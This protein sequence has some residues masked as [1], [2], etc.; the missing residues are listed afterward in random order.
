MAGSA[1]ARRDVLAKPTPDAKVRSVSLLDLPSELLAEIHGR[2]DFVDQLNLA[3]SCRGAAGASSWQQR[4]KTTP[5]LVALLPTRRPLRN[6]TRRGPRDARPR[7]LGSTDGW[8]VT[9]DVRATL[10]MANPVTGEQAA[11]PPITAGTIPFFVD[12]WPY[13]IDMN[14][15]RK[16]TGGHG[17]RP[18][19]YTISDWQMRN[20]FYRKVILSASPRPG[21]YTAMLILYK[22]FA[23]AAAFATADD[24]TWRLAAGS[25]DGGGVEDAICHNGR[26]YSVTYAGDVVAWDYDRRHA[27]A[28]EFASVAVWPRLS[29]DYLRLRRRKYIAAAPDGRLVVVIK[30]MKEAID[31]HPSWSSRMSFVFQVFVLDVARQRWV[32]TKDIGDLALSVGVNTSMC[33]STR[34]HPGIRAGCVYY[35]ED[36][37]GEASLRLEDA[38]YAPGEL[39]DVG[40][41]VLKDGT[42]D[43]VHGLRH[44]HRYWPL[45]AWFMPCM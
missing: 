45:P 3:V 28:S 10:R 19:S 43:S 35:M 30:D 27:R 7:I 34:E 37:L 40:V 44:R 20:W 9:V 18:P 32:E 21:S 22:R 4:H 5:C 16:L 14:L 24:Q 42:V 12:S 11:L 39:Q 26:F 31:K 41:Y 2:H 38:R 8:I 13:L 29:G 17:D 25:G 1:A 36:E 15:F 33:V 23:G 6:L